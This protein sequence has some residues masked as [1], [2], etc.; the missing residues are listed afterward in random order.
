MRAFC[1]AGVHSCLFVFSSRRRHT[2]LVSDWSSD[3]CSSDLILLLAIADYLMF[4]Y[5]Q[6]QN[7]TTFSDIWRLPPAHCL[8]WSPGGS[9]SVRCYWTLE[10]RDEI[11]RASCRERV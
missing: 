6:Q 10:P 5:H 11:G 2:R 1:L 3:V 4:G 8:T 9:P 7:A